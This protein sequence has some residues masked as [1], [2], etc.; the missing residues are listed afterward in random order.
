[1]VTFVDMPQSKQKRLRAE[2]A[3]T[4]YIATQRRNRRAFYWFQVARNRIRANSAHRQLWLDTYRRL[5]G[6]GEYYQLLQ[7]YTADALA[8]GN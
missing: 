6:V 5:F 3:P 1:M 8:K 2:Y 4:P 7:E